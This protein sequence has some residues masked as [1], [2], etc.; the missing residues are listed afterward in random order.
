[1]TRT[2]QPKTL[3]DGTPNPKYTPQTNRHHKKLLP[4]GTPN[5]S[6]RP[7]TRKRSGDRHKGNHA[8]PYRGKDTFIAID[9]EGITLENG[10]HRY[11][12]LMAST[13]EHVIN[14]KGLTS[15][16]CFEFLLSLAKKY[17]HG[18]FV[19]FAASYDVNMMLGNI[20]QEKLKELWARRDGKRM[21]YLKHRGHEFAVDYRPRKYFYLGKIAR[22]VWNEKENKPD[23]VYEASIK[24]W[25]VF[26]FF[27]KPFVE[28]LETWFPDGLSIDLN[29]MKMMK[30]TRRTFTTAQLEEIKAYCLQECEALARL[31][32]RLRD[33]LHVVDITLSQW[34]G[35][36]AIASALLKRE[37]VKEHARASLEKDT[38]D[39]CL[40]AYAGGRF[41]A[42]Q[43]GMH[44]GPVYNY[45][46]RSAFPSVMPDL[47][48]MKN[49]MWRKVGGM[50]NHPYS[51]MHVRWRLDDRLPY[52]PF[53]FRVEDGSIYFPNAGEGWYHR[54][55]V[56][57]AL[58]A[59]E[60]GK[61]STKR[62]KGVIDILETWEFHPYEQ[63]KPFAFVPE[64]FKQRQEW[65]ERG[66][67]AEKVLKLGL[68]SFYGKTA[69]SV[70]GT[71][72]EPP[73]YHNIYWAGFL[74]AAIRA[75]IFDAIMQKPE[76]IVL[77]AVDG[78]YSTEQLDLDIGKGLGQWEVHPVDGVVVVQ[79][80]VYFG[81]RR[82]DRE[83]T[84][85]EQSDTRKYWQH[86][87]AWYRVN[88][89][90]RG[91][92]RN[93]LT[94]QTVIDGW[95][96]YL[97]T[98]PIKTP[99]RFVTLGSALAQKGTLWEHWRTWR[100]V[101]RK[102]ELQPQGKRV[103]LST[104]K[105]PYNQLYQTLAAPPYHSTATVS[106][107]YKLAWE[108]DEE[109]DFGKIDGIDKEIVLGEIDEAEVI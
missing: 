23:N 73:P 32:G 40:R 51:L 80:G 91:F 86:E 38:H 107:G 94:V 57:A 31:M 71:A 26:N 109:D 88:P 15:L 54:S 100:T 79:S 34:Q 81:L 102:L 53:F 55:E 72:E 39:A 67:P 47:P 14:E 13:G 44:I 18:I 50:T 103:I 22:R 49:G 56:D 59:Y 78:I 92:D 108:R 41:E 21:T 42:G 64:L 27:Q 11:I 4:D 16:E 6:Y 5:P 89:H 35:S 52:Y 43:W 63:T 28:T 70:G 93:T 105:T 19:C 60:Q 45:D 30:A 82:V 29:H 62:E 106:Q 1:M 83:L 104:G 46:V 95:E 12:L 85:E 75:K 37:G 61:L 2:Y 98:L 101:E 48:S 24:L 90:Y 66:N 9:G 97:Y 68:N 58:C 10:E 87:G 69:Q 77:V 8:S 74:T 96:R 20:N 17:K 7:D 3:S 76:H 84:P 99:S 36:G 33:Y 65:K 25:D